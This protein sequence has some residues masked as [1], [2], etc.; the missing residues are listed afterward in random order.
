M[1]ILLTGKNGQVGWELARALLPLGN[2]AAFDHAGLDLAVA[3]AV[4]RKLDEVRPDAIVNAAAYTAV[5]RAESEPE[6]AS[7]INAAAPALLAQEAARRGALLIHYSTDYVFDGAKAAPYVETDP[8]APLG[9][10]GRSK[11]AG[12]EGIRA[13]GCEHLIFRTSWVYGARGANFLRTILRLAAERE[14][15]RVVNDQIGAP[16]WARL[17]AEATAHALKQAMR[18]RRD[19]AF[20]S[21]TYHLAAAGETSW[22][23]FA[24]AI[25]AGRSGL[26]V[27][28]VTPI[29]T[30]DYPLPAPRPANSR[31]DTA[32]F[33]ARFDLV[34][35]DWRD[36][37]PLCLEEIPQ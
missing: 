32:A 18:E 7:A 20:R 3:A 5:D 33:R 15:L 31:L 9:A 10:Y 6:L 11:L 36:C 1:N 2:V 35:P 29:A 16:T 30:A 17:I 37:L 24:S 26:R 27:K 12:E 23:G 22:H 13:A 28:A 34:L 25:V 21:G 8:T 14:E 4:R 19:R